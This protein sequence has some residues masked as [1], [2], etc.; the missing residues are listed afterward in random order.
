MISY[1]NYKMQTF[2][3]VSMRQHTISI[4]VDHIKILCILIACDCTLLF[5]AEKGKKLHATIPLNV[6]EA[7][8]G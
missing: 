6:R 4:V 5:G 7:S 3:R 2:D 8:H 1:K